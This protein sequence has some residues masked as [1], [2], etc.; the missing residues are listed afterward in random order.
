MPN[1]FTLVALESE[2]P[3]EEIIAAVEGGTWRP[4]EPYG[5]WRQ[6]ELRV[7]AQGQRVVIVANACQVS[8]TGEDVIPPAK[9]LSP[10][11]VASAARTL[12]RANNK[13]NCHA[14]WG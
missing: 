2:Q 14:A 6:A 3:M 5:A 13:R 4:P 12:P 8:S 10:R 11:R 9:A 1:E 7:L